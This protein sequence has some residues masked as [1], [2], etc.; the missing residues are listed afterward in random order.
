MR[1]RRVAA[2]CERNCRR[3]VPT[4]T[5]TTTAV[6]AVCQWTTT[7]ALRRPVAASGRTPKLRRR[8]RRARRVR[9]APLFCV[10][11]FAFA[12]RHWCCGR[13]GPR[14]AA[15]FAARGGA[16]DATEHCSRAPRQ[17]SAARCAKHRHQLRGH[18][19]PPVDARR[20]FCGP[21]RRRAVPDRV[22]GR[23]AAGHSSF[24]SAPQRHWYFF[25]FFFFVI[26][27]SGCSQRR[28]NWVWTLPKQWC[29]S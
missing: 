12:C 15:R 22:A 26:L 27:L 13:N 29:R 6:A 8:R 23:L 10:A 2:T 16:V 7:A 21:A 17:F 19:A 11:Q 24:V 5:T 18:R 20:L 25:F 4:A 1:G 9:V 14:F 3:T 28:C